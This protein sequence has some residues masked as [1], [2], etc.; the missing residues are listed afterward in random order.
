MPVVYGV[1]SLDGDPAVAYCQKHGV[2][3]IVGIQLTQYGA[4]VVLN[5]L[6]ANAQDIGDSFI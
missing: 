4:Y 5:C 6:F 2:G 1:I 3:P